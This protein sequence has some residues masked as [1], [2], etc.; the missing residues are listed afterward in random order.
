M[1]NASLFGGFILKKAFR[2]FN[3]WQD[4][5][6]ELMKELG[7]DLNSALQQVTTGVYFFNKIVGSL[8]KLAGNFARSIGKLTGKI[9]TFPFR[10]AGRIIRTAVRKAFVGIKKAIGPG[11]RKAIK[12]FFNIGK[13][14]TKVGTKVAGK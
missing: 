1:H 4:G 3:A 2:L 7:I 6:G 11:M 10:V 14:S 5:N 8:I 13:N 9:I 12:G